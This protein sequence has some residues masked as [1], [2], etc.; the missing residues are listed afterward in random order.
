MWKLNNTFLNNEKIKEETKA[1]TK[2]T[3]K[4]FKME[5]QHTNIYRIQESHSKREVYSNKHYIKK[6]QI[7]NL[8]SY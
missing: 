1:E 7:Y 6:S 5:I 2:Y 4:Q 8:V 3:L